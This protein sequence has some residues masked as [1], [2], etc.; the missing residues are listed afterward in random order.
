MKIEI[1]S[2][3]NGGVL[4][5]IETDNMRLAVEAAIK[6]RADL[7]RA[8]LTGA[9]L[10]GAYLTGAT[11]TGA[12]LTRAYLTRANLTGANLT[13]TVLDP[14]AI[15]PLP[16][17]DQWRSWGFEVEGDKIWC[18][19]TATSQ[20][21]GSTDYTPAGEYVAPVFSIDQF[22]ACHPGIYF[23]TKEWCETNYPRVPIV[24]G[25]V[26][27]TEAIKAQDKF[28]AKRFFRPEEV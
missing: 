4:F 2:W 26:L 22:T 7:S 10:S 21:C 13:N 9:N 12:Y 20:H 16:T 27:I 8:D 3:F 18:W 28:R 23:G 6:S 14:L 5:A 25:Y 24:R 17:A 19:R 11:L 15:L 1:K